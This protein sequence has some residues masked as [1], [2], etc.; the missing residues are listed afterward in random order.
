LLRTAD[1]IHLAVALRLRDSPGLDYFMCADADLCEV[2]E[3][4]QLSVINP[5]LS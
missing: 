1:A 3:A 5:E 2:A 4:E